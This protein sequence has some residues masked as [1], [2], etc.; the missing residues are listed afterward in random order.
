MGTGLGQRGQKEPC[1]TPGEAAS[2]HRSV[3]RAAFF[4]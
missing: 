2:S 1:Q 3:L 4:T